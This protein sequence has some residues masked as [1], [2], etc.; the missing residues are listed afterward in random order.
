MACPC[1]TDMSDM[2]IV[3]HDNRL[4]WTCYNLLMLESCQTHGQWAASFDKTMEWEPPMVI[5]TFSWSTTRAN[6]HVRVHIHEATSRGVRVL[7][8]RHSQHQAFPTLL[9][10][11]RICRK[12]GNAARMLALRVSVVLCLLHPWRNLR[13]PL[14]E[15]FS[16]WYIDVQCI[17][18]AI[19]SSMLH[20]LL[21]DS[22]N[23]AFMNGN[24]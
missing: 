19:C 11:H 23:S 1:Q 16:E 14:A 2:I 20:V 8:A 7:K 15:G 17:L 6:D 13:Q 3:W 24:A 12:A 9:Q 4:T 21:A 5:H 10:R 18:M 22:M